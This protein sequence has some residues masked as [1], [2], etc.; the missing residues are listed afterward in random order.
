MRML[1]HWMARAVSLFGL[2]CLRS[3]LEGFLCKGFTCPKKQYCQVR[4]TLD[5]LEAE[6][7]FVLEK[8]NFIRS[9]PLFYF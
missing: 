7:I 2:F 3:S 4:R 8:I 5:V 9:Q 6:V 1:L